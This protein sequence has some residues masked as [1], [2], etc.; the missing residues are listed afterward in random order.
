M[1]AAAAR[2]CSDDHGGGGS[3]SL[4]RRRADV[5]GAEPDRRAAGG[6]N[7]TVNVE[8]DASLNANDPKPATITIVGAANDDTIN[9]GS[10]NDVVTVGNR[11]TVNLGTGNDTI[12][13]NSATIGATIGNGTGQN[14]LDVTGGGTITMGPHITDIANVVLAPASVAYHFTAN[15]ISGL[16]VNDGNTKTADTLTAGG[17]HQILTGGGAGSV[18]FIGA[19]AGADTFKDTA[20]LFNH[21]TIAGFG[22]NGDVHLPLAWCSSLSIA[23]VRTGRVGQ[24]ATADRMTMGLSLIGAMVSRVM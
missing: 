3:V 16:T 21:D 6:L 23:V 24:P 17:A 12:I 14:T 7:A 2:Q 9:L 13:V 18:E 1:T 10:G 22:T 19:A 15:A 4:Q 8:S 5:L 11:E 20:A